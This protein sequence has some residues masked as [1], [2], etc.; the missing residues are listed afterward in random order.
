MEPEVDEKTCSPWRTATYKL[1]GVGIVTQFVAT[2]QINMT[3]GRPNVL[4]EQLQRADL[5]LRRFPFESHQSWWDLEFEFRFQLEV[6]EFLRRVLGR[7]IW[8]TKKMQELN[9]INGEAK[10][11]PNELLVLVYMDVTKVS[12]VAG[13]LSRIQVEDETRVYFGKPDPDADVPEGC[14]GYE[15]RTQ[16]KTKMA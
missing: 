10:K 11:L 8:A 12:R 3:K 13:K 7:L 9:S 2:P 4:F 5:N 6:P 15:W 14:L 1:P 16:M